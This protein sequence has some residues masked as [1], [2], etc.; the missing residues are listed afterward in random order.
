MFQIKCET[1]LPS[2]RQDRYKGLA[3]DGCRFYLTAYCT[4]E[5]LQLDEQFHKTRTIRTNRCY[6]YLCY[7]PVAHCFW[8]AAEKCLFTLYRLSECF[9]ELECIPL[10][11]PGCRDGVVTGLSRDCC[12]GE[13][14]AAFASCLVRVD[15]CRPSAAHVC[16]TADR[17]WIAGVLSLCPYT[18][19]CAMGAK[20]QTIRILT[21][22]GAV[23]GE[24]AMPAGCTL[25]AAVFAPCG[26][27]CPV[28]RFCALITKCGGYPYLLECQPEYGSLC[29]QISG[30]N[31][32]IC[33]K[34][35]HS[36]GPH[37]PCDSRESCCEVLES[38][39]LVET[40]IAHILN[41]E[42]EKLQKAI[43]S[44]SDVCKLL[45]VNESVRKTI[46]KATH[47][48]GILYDKMNAL[49]DLCG[50]DGLCEKKHHPCKH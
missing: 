4:P 12:T 18:L 47:M 37:R 16:Y 29:E 45:E 39:A 24:V 5:I 14:V 9:E 40:S 6:T 38:V 33:R 42:G 19:F 30:C 44:T 36:G 13:L 17:D 8:A 3:Y 43:A 34:D 2:E 49:R 35:C 1:P 22:S 26:E 48:E 27:E 11:A 50:P 10:R 7:D 15:P 46:E 23:A 28:C 25:E 41:A 31:F 20:K 21:H 32:R